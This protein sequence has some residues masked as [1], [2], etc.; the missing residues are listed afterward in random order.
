MS[1][2]DLV[3][4]GLTEFEE[5]YVEDGAKL[6]VDAVLAATSLRADINLGHGIKVEDVQEV[7]KLVEAIDKAETVLDTRVWADDEDEGDA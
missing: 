3:V 5:E 1:A 2:Y 4:R 7:L 6:L